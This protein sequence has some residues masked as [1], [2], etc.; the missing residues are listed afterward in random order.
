MLAVLPQLFILPGLR[1][2]YCVIYMKIL[3]TY[4]MWLYHIIPQP[5]IHIDHCYLQSTYNVVHLHGPWTLH[6]NGAK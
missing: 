2:L 1:Q 5:L 6:Y 3:Q 4:V